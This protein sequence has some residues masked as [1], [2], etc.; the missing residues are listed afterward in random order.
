MQFASELVE[1]VDNYHICR[2]ENCLCFSPNT[3][4]VQEYKAIPGAD[5]DAYFAALYDTTKRTRHSDDLVEVVV[6][7]KPPV[8]SLLHHFRCSACGLE[9]GPWV[10]KSHF[11]AANKILVAALAG[12][13][14]LAKAMG[15][16]A[17]D[18]KYWYCNWSDTK[19]TV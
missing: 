5:S 8:A 18:V 16:G 11:I 4:W 3:C 14:L 9:Y 15:M 12:D 19:T 13:T 6:D 10:K 7:D 17:N 1:G 2:D